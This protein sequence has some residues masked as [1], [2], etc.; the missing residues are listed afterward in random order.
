[1]AE[2]TA[3]VGTNL[4]IFKGHPDELKEQDINA[5]VMSPE[6]FERLTENIKKESRLES[7]PFAVCRPGGKFEL[8]SGHHRKRAAVAAGLT[9]IFWLADTREDMTRSALV[10]KQLAHN[11]IFGKDDPATLKRLYDELDNIDAIIESFLRPEDF[12]SV[13]QLEPASI[14][15]ISV[16]IQWKHLGLVFVPKTMEAIERIDDWIK[17]M[18]KDTDTIG[19]VSIEVLDRFRKAAL[20]ISRTEDV[21]SLGA[22]VTRMCEI[23]EE[24]L[25][26]VEAEQAEL[27]KEGAKAK[28]A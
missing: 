10:A 15:D 17:R 6:M 13:K 3:D 21:R 26:R 11:A 28:A 23:T 27:K 19:V 22:I 24:H 1:M 12:D 16:G 8:A 18:P 14:T 25:A 9:E 4:A 7:L 20:N 5:H 2:K